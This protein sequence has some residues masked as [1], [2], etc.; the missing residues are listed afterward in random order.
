MGKKRT[1]KYK[2]HVGKSPGT[3][4]YTGDKTAQKLFIESFDYNPEFINE[5]MCHYLER[6]AYTRYISLEEFKGN[7]SFENK[8]IELDS[9]ENDDYDDIELELS[10]LYI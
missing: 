7:N 9:F 5:L 8:E 4:I 2:K 1:S 10:I 6:K 3:L